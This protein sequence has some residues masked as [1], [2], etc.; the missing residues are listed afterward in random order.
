MQQPIVVYNGYNWWEMRVHVFWWFDS[1]LSRSILEVWLEEDPASHPAREMPSRKSTKS[2][3][4]TKTSTGFVSFS[5]GY[6]KCAA[7]KQTRRLSKSIPRF[8]VV[9]KQSRFQHIQTG[10]ELHLQGAKW[11]KMTRSGQ[12][13][14]QK[15]AVR[16]RHFR[17]LIEHHLTSSIQ[18]QGIKL[19]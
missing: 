5:E 18:S 19:N 2:A 6:W 3:L 12:Q 1:E 9:S 4:V 13:Q 17:N 7:K 14:F 10:S 11:C 16:L 8:N 15:E